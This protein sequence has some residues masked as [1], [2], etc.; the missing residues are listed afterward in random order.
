MDEKYV[1]DTS[2]ALKWFLNDESDTDKADLIQEAFL[3][4]E[5]DLIAP[6]HFSYE[7]ADALDKASRSNRIPAQEARQA[8]RDF[9]QIAIP[10]QIQDNSELLKTW[11][12]QLSI[13]GRYYD[14]A[15]LEL[16]LNSNCKVI[17][18]DVNFQS[19]DPQNIQLLSSLP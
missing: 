16:A 11:D 19:L 5:I 13:K 18:A 17:T 14:M 12:L 4:Q 15:F 10:I 2:V 6:P 1:I 9:L 7:F 3:K 8:F